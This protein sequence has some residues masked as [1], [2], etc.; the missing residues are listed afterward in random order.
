ME[1][2]IDDP[3]SW[4]NS[5]PPE[6]VDRWIVYD[7]IKPV[8]RHVPL[9]KVCA[10]VYQLAQLAAAKLGVSMPARSYS[11]WLPDSQDQDTPKALSGDQSRDWVE[12]VFAAGRAAA[13]M[14][15]RRKR[16][17]KKVED[18]NHD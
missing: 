4:F 6:V 1:L 8:S 2:G 14:A 10:E 12:H 18:G 11:Y 9:A 15:L 7:R 13:A 16:R 3:E 5:V 17:R